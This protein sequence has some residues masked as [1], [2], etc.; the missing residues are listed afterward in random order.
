MARNATFLFS[1]VVQLIVRLTALLRK[2]TNTLTIFVDLSVD[3][4]AYL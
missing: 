4:L 3:W 1:D 2:G